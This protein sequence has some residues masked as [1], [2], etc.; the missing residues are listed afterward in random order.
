MDRVVLQEKSIIRYTKEHS[1]VKKKF[2]IIKNI[3]NFIRQN[4]QN[5]KEENTN[6]ESEWEILAHV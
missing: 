3:S 1:K 4:W 6:S 2:Q 5:C